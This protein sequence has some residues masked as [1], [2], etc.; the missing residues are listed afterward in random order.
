MERLTYREH[1]MA[2]PRG[3]GGGIEGGTKWQLLNALWAREGAR[4]TNGMTERK[5]VSTALDGLTP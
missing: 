3:G 5:T 4:P 1:R 2:D